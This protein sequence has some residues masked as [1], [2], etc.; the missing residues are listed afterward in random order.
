MVW[1]IMRLFCGGHAALQ[2]LEPVLHH[3]DLRQR[4][5]FFALLDHQKSLA[6]GRYIV[7]ME[8]IGTRQIESQGEEHPWF[9]SRKTRLCRYIDSHHPVPAAV[10]QLPAVGIPN[11]LFTP[12]GRDLPSSTRAGMRLHE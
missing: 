7:E 8:P 12:F 2:F 1:P 3:H 10:E 11:R 4:R 5:S 6:V 9:P